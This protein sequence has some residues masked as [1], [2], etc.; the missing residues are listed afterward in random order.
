[1][2]KYLKIIFILVLIISCTGCVKLEEDM[3]I[4]KNKS[5]KYTITLSSDDDD[6]INKYLD[7][8][9]IDRLGKF[10]KVEEISNKK[11][12]AYKL[13]WNVSNIDDIS[14]TSDIVFSLNTIKDSIPTNIF[15]VSK[16][17][18][19]N[20][21]TADFIFT[22]DGII[23]EDTVIDSNNNLFTFKVDLDKESI[24]NNA[25]T[26][27]DNTLIWN[28]DGNSTKEINFKFSLYNYSHIIITILFGLFVIF[29]VYL[30]FKKILEKRF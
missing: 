17:W 24:S 9:T 1:M 22:L 3:K 2:K 8:E 25:D 30:S 10:Y 4:N 14:S 29:I 23:D 12:K 26:I 16:S 6:F 15:I 27:K 19:Y 21:Y 28:I 20:V 11:G 13:T 18:F 7:N 5:M